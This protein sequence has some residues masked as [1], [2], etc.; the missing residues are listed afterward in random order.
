MLNDPLAAQVA[1][2]VM[3]AEDM[4]DLLKNAGQQSKLDPPLDAATGAAYDL[5]GYLAGSDTLVEIDPITQKRRLRASGNT[6]FYG[7]V[8][9][10]KA[11]PHQFMAVIRGTGDL[12]EWIKD[13]EFSPV[14]HQLSGGHVEMGFDSIYQT[15]QYRPY[16]GGAFTGD[17]RRAAP[18]IAQ[19]APDGKVT[20]VG[21]SL[22]ST[23][24]TYLALEL[25]A[26][27]QMGDRIT[28]CMFA[29]PRPGDTPF[30]DFFDATLTT[31][32][33]YNYSRDAVPMVPL[34]FGYS[35]LPR[36]V[37]ITPDSA[38]ANIR[39]NPLLP[40]DIGNLACQHHA[41][42]YAAM[43]DYHAA[44][45]AHLPPIDQAC[46]QCIVGPKSVAT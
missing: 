11:N 40:L 24:A 17:W 37:R 21:H 35:S 8:V 20:V 38:Q 28:T 29:S 45:W 19:A 41:V 18:A 32:T 16:P 36:A 15:L 26:G 42:C 2:L 7:F 33:L 27:Q 30:V 22:G 1:L 6:V 14:P 44:D 10:S 3:R 4:F 25:A 31:Y 23:L 46:V 34:L 5:T 9:S 12:L 43:L 13:A 39:Y